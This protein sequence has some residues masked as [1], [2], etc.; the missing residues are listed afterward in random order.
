MQISNTR[1]TVKF[2]NRFRAHL[3][4]SDAELSFQGDTFREF[5]PALL[6][7]FDLADLLLDGD[8]I[9][10]RVH[11]VINGRYSHLIGGWDAPVADGS[12]VVLTFA[13]GKSY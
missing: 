5:I 11:V 2:A 9:N 13:Y 12:T 10:S 7:Q 1:V 4:Q 8:Q 6:A 3:R